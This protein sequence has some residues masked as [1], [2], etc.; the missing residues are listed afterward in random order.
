MD[1][2]GFTYELRIKTIVDN[3]EREL[4]QFGGTLKKSW[5]NG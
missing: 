2:Q 5:E 4:K 3:A 1:K